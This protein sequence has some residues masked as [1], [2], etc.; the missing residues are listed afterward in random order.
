MSSLGALLGRIFSRSVALELM[1]GLNFV[2]PLLATPN[3]GT[4]VIDVS[5]SVT[6]QAGKKSG[7][8]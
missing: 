4:G 3:P 6:C 7:R 1:G 5:T 2:A 8:D